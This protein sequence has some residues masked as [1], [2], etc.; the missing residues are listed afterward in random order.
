[1]NNYLNINS[2][3]LTHEKSDFGVPINKIRLEI[4]QL[5]DHA[6][7]FLILDAKVIQSFI[8]VSHRFT[9]IEFDVSMIA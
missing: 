8:I 7:P 4:V 3:V 5:I 9:F 6:F 1:M 2:T